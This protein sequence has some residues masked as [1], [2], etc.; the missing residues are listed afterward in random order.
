VK[1][2]KEKAK[3]ELQSKPRR[4]IRLRLFLIQGGGG[5]EKRMRKR[6]D[7]NREQQRGGGKESNGLGSTL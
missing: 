6:L 3:S 2:R 7:R 1:Q 5:S 4:S